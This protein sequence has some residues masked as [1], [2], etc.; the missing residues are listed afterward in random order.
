MNAKLTIMQTTDWTKF[1][2]E[3]WC[4]QLGAWINGDTEKMVRVVKTMP[5][6]RITQKQREKLLAMY[7]NDEQLKVRLCI[8]KTG[9]CC[10][11][12]ENEARAI[13]RLFMDLQLIE[14]EVLQEWISAIWSHHVLGNSLRE[15]AAGCDTSVNQIRQ[16]LKCGFAYIKS[17]YSHF[18]FEVFT[19]VV[20]EA[21][22]KEKEIIKTA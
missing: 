21:E 1:T 6:K 22:G 20:E 11:L 8:K 2:F 19:K 9:T 14:D 15:I 5:T 7:M 12:N 13:Q 18:A 4:R 10:Q 3:G 17:R 16:D